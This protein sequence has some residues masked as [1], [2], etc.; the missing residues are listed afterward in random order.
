MNTLVSEKLWEH[1]HRACFFQQPDIKSRCSAQGQRSEELRVD[2]WSISDVNV[3]FYSPVQS[4]YWHC[5]S[6]GSGSHRARRSS[7][8]GGGAWCTPVHDHHP[9]G[10]PND[11]AWDER[12]KDWL[13]LIS[14][15]HHESRCDRTQW[16]APE[17]RK[18]ELDV[19]LLAERRLMDGSR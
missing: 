3:R 5:T 4:V 18:D 15:S 12:A 11:G 19:G 16:K 14:H 6:L 9:A 17:E 2:L 10:G 13:G 8:W 1:S 7:L